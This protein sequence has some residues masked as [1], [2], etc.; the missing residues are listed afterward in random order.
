MYRDSITYYDSYIKSVFPVKSAI[1]Q[2]R[3]YI[4]NSYFA[5]VHKRQRSPTWQHRVTDP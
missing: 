4:H 3:K 1:T 5:L 2:R